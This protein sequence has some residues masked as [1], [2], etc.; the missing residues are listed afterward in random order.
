MRYIDVLSMAILKDMGLEVY[1]EE[2]TEN[3]YWKK[4]NSKNLKE[5]KTMKKLILKRYGLYNPTEVEYGDKILVTNQ[6]DVKSLCDLWKWYFNLE[7]YKK[8]PLYVLNE[9]D[10]N[11]M[12]QSNNLNIKNVYELF[13]EQGFDIKLL[14]NKDEV[15]S[16]WLLMRND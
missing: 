6:L 16:K 4:L 9:K 11:S 10:F 1:D 2:L 5:D 12:Q 13:E 15:K 7:C 3:P 8:I 14:K